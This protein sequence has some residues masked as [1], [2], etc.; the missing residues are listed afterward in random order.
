MT[1]ISLLA[2]CFGIAMV[3]E[4]RGNKPSGVL[5]GH[6]EG[7]A[8]VDI[9]HE[10]R[11]KAAMGPKI[12]NEMGVDIH[13][14]MQMVRPLSTPQHPSLVSPQQDQHSGHKKNCP[15]VVGALYR[16]VQNRPTKRCCS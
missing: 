11:E 5:V 10:H 8:Y 1:H 9:K 2:S 14:E 6:S 3:L 7:W 16:E 4:V 13:V 15:Y 12:V